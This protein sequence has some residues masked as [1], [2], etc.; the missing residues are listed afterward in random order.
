MLTAHRLPCSRLRPYIDRYW[1]WRAERGERVSVVQPVP[2]TGADFFFHM[3]SP[4]VTGDGRKLPASHLLC[5]REKNI[6]FTEVDHADWFVVRFRAAALR[7]F[8]GVPL[9][10][11]GDTF[12]GPRDLFGP[13]GEQ[14]AS[15]LTDAAGFEARAAVADRYLLEL[16]VRHRKHDAV[17][18]A[19]VRRIYG[20]YGR[21][22]IHDLARELG[23]SQR[24]LQ[25]RFSEVLGLSAKHFARLS[26]FHH[27]IR[28]MLLEGPSEHT[29]IALDA[30]YYDHAH[31]IHEF[32]A[33]T[34]ERPHDFLRAARVRSHFYNRPL[35][36]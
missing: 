25:R 28:T 29:P 13:A 23:V 21:I 36:R 17:L 16:F 1:S 34:G 3:G 22:G 32:R 5:V 26:R 7:H 6:R 8:S 12:A 31:F 20:V 15:E 2:G 27:A 18:D 4:F 9:A 11:L 33:L 14:F 10:A 35:S 30:G 19:A 24:H